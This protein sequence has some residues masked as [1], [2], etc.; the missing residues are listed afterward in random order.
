[1][2]LYNIIQETKQTF[3]NLDNDW[4]KTAPNEK[5]IILSKSLESV[6]TLLDICH[7]ENDVLTKKNETTRI[8]EV[9]NE[10]QEKLNKCVFLLAQSGIVGVNQIAEIL[11]ISTSEA[12]DKLNSWKK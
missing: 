9:D 1:M 2:N 4:I 5:I 10:A 7:Q 6:K 11:N 3:Q 8:M 12:S